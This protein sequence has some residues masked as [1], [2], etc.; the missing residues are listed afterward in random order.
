MKSPLL[1]L[2]ELFGGLLKSSTDTMRFV[3]SKLIE[4][5]ISLGFMAGTSPLGLVIAIAIATA[6]IFFIMKFVFGASKNLIIIMLVAV[7]LFIITIL[8]GT[9]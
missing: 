3:G 7:V 5:F 2:L 4:L 9:A 6:V 1:I 8:L